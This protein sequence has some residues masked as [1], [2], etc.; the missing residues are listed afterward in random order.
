[1]SRV[2]FVLLRSGARLADESTALHERAQRDAAVA[3]GRRA[4]ER[5]YLAAL[6]DTAASTM[7][8]AG[9]GMVDGREPWMATQAARDVALLT[10]QRPGGRLD[11][12]RVLADV[13]ERV[14][15]AVTLDQPGELRLPAAAALALSQSVREAL[16]NVARHAGVQEATVVVTGSSD[17]VSI[18]VTDPGRG[19]DPTTVSPHRRGISMSI[20]ERM[21][22]ADGTATVESRPGAG[23]TVRLSWTAP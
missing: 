6:H 17:E 15:L 10:E 3:A 21:G 18:V 14:P 16:A 22:R 13:V 23:T 7:L 19:F 1:M 11:L 12:T 2:I 4:E 8:A 5:E 9:L 20:V